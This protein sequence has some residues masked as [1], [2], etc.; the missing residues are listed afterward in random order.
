MFME[1]RW[2]DLFGIIKLINGTGI[3]LTNSYWPMVIL[4]VTGLAF[5][6]GLYIFMMR[7]FFRGVPDELEESAYIDG[8]GTLRTFLQIILPLSVPMMIT[9]FLFAFS[10][11][12]TDDFYTEMFFSTNKITLMPD[13]VGIPKSL[14]TTYAGQSLYYTAINN[15]CGLMI[16]IPL[17]IMYLFCQ[18]YLVQGI[19]R[20]GIVG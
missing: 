17:V 3:Q 8:S 7:Q 19:E 12:W 13:I 2:F 20:S 14:E 18:R 10:W 5:K 16:I 1:F 15:T 9:I 11:Q 4:S 6:N